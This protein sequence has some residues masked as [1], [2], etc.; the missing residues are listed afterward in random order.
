MLKKHFPEDPQKDFIPRYLLRAHLAQH[1]VIATCTLYFIRNSFIQESTTRCLHRVIYKNERDTSPTLHK[2]LQVTQPA[3][4][5]GCRAG[6]SGLKA[7]ASLQLGSPK[8]WGEGR[9]FPQ[10]TDFLLCIFYLVL[11]SIYFLANTYISKR[12]FSFRGDE[13]SDNKGNL[14]KLKRKTQIKG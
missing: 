10:T 9:C 4:W 11:L 5:G 13:L 7:A 12:V 6:P 1:K 14:R 8:K 2:P 3:Q